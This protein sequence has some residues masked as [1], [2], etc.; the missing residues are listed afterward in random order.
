MKRFV[1]P[2]AGFLLLSFGFLI[3]FSVARIPQ[4]P[5]SDQPVVA[6]PHEGTYAVA[7]VLDGD[8]IELSSG[9]KVRYL[10][11]DAP[12]LAQSWGEKA[13][14]YNK[15][16]VEGKMV[17][18][19]LDR[20]SRDPYGRILAYVW[21]EETLVN[22]AL[23]HEGYARYFSPKGEPVPKHRDRIQKAEREAK[24]DHR[25]IWMEEWIN[26]NENKSSRPLFPGTRGSSDGRRQAALSATGSFFADLFRIP[27]PLI[28]RRQTINKS[29]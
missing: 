5:S 25:G 20:I 6:V 23:V 16:L 27:S 15:K 22:E 4:Q 3:G 18:I 24:E 17:R 11:I 26:E 2:V 8:T 12:E 28:Y 19:E 21:V 1:S 13:W 9:E 14:E 29:L 10:G 7:R